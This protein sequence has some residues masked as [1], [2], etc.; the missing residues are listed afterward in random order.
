MGVFRRIYELLLHRGVI[1][2][3][4]VGCHKR[5]TPTGLGHTHLEQL[6]VHISLSQDSSLP[7][8]SLLLKSLIL[9]AN[10]RLT[11][12]LPAGAALYRVNA[13]GTLSGV[14]Q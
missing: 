13:D 1:Q 10:H 8:D 6:A 3:K 11:G 5:F 12:P 4:Q 7:T 14:R 9:K 2:S